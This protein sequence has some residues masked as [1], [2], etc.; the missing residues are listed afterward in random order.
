MA[1]KPVQNELPP[2]A[3]FKPEV[4]P[5]DPPAP[6]RRPGAWAGLLWCEWFA[7]SRLL[8]LFL[9]LWLVAVWSLPLVGHSG[10]ILTV[11]LAFA[12]LAGPA[13][14]GGDVVDGCE[15]F[16][17]SLPATRSERYLARLMVGGGA[18]AAFA[19]MDLAVLGFDLPQ[20]LSRLYVDAGVLQPVQA[21]RTEPAYVLALVFPFTV[22]AGAFAVAAVARSRALV[23]MAWFWGGL[24]ALLVLF[25]GIQYETLVLHKLSGVFAGPLLLVTSVLVLVLGRHRYRRKEVGVVA[26]PIQ[27][28]GHWWAWLILFLLGLALATALLATLTRQFPGM[29]R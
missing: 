27:L 3:V 25:L 26:R 15:E 29:F 17:F 5:L 24:G 11:G 20:I 19:L 7:H 8:L 21:A 23:L 1:S 4:V 28:P 6:A 9:A 22:F 12:L 2:G 13:Y 18:V 10:W 16:S 14:G